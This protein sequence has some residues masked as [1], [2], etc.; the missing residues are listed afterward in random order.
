LSVCRAW[1]R[2]A[3]CSTLCMCAV[4]RTAYT[5]WMGQQW[6]LHMFMPFLVRGKAA[7]A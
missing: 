7:E 5:A 1:M 4:F 3:V 6:E 2:H